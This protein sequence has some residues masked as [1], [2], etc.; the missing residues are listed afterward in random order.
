MKKIVI[1][2]WCALTGCPYENGKEIPYSKKVRCEVISNIL[3][4]NLH[5]MV[6]DCDDVCVV[7]VDCNHQ[8]FK[9]R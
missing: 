9:Q 7:S 1:Y 4:A 2:Y 6:K 8:P 3:D 5:V